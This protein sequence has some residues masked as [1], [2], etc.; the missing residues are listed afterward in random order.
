M[1]P[2]TAN[3][4]ITDG[5]KTV[6]IHIHPGVHFSP[7]VNREV[8]SADVAYAIERA[9]NP[10]VGSAYFQSYFGAGA[11]A[12]LAAPPAPT[13]R[14][15][16]SPASRRRTSTTIVL[17]TVKPSGAFL[18]QALSLPI[19]A[20][21]PESFAGPMDK[22]S[23]T[24]YGTKYLVATGPY[25]IQSR[26]QDGAVPGHRLPDRQVADPG[27]QPQ[28]ERQD[29][30]AS[31][32]PG[33]DQLRHRRRRDRD[34]PA[35]A[36]G[37]RRGPVR[38]AGPGDGQARLPELPVPDHVHARAPA[39]TT[40]R[41]TTTPGRSRTSTCAGRR[42]PIS[43]A[44][45]SSSCAAARS[46]ASPRRTSSIPASTAMQQAGGAAGTT[47]PWNTN[48]NGNLSGGSEVHEGRRLQLGQVHRQPPSRSSAPTTATT[49]R[50][51]SSSTPT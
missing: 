24:T 35:G 14:A 31:G 39:T 5:G 17:H 19:S 43:T 46:P 23:P 1:I 15:A 45:R 50:S 49:R 20:P 42:G 51:S 10:N 34:R 13:T 22:Q 7:P 16:R 41:S 2:T 36:Q 3:G 38:H 8:T 26:P 12:P 47:V 11:P 18:V 29:R 48:V 33:P 30:L 44:P 4:G 25:M 37:L 27:A 6:T 9:A 28:L 21:V 32:V 40:R